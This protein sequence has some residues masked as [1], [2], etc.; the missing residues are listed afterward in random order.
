MGQFATV[1]EPTADRAV[2]AV[3]RKRKFPELSRFSSR[4]N[5]PNRISNPSD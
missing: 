1:R 2:R 4:P 5:M 3:P